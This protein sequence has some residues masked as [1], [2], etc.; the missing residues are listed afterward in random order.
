MMGS[1]LL[2]PFIGFDKITKF[3]FDVSNEFI[4]QKEFDEAYNI[5]QSLS[6]SP[7]VS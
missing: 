1:Y 6:E 5:L 7:E 3:A 4:R 2:S